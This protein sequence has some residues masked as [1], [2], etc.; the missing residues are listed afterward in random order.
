M[1]D[2]IADI[3]LGQLTEANR[4]I[5][6]LMKDMAVVKTKL[7]MYSLMFGGGISLAITII[8]KLI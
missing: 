1:D 6:E 3:I 4:K 2:R 7:A 8:G 5:D